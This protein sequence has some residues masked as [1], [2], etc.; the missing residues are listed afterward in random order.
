MVEI[1][2]RTVSSGRRA[3]STPSTITLPLLNSANRN[4]AA[5]KLDLPAGYV[6][7]SYVCLILYYFN[8]DYVS[9]RTPVHLL[10]A[11]GFTCT[12]LLTLLATMFSQGSD[13]DPETIEH[14]TQT[15]I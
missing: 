3:R 13:V 9:S 14:L 1:E 5:P 7:M 15:P 2:E 12:G 4:I 11:P 6:G 10:G 8:T